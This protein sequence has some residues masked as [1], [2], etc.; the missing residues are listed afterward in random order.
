MNE[1]AY[2]APA[3]R[4]L[5]TVEELTQDGILVKLGSRS[6][7]FTLLSD[8]VTLTGSIVFIGNDVRG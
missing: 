8:N 1:L 3:L 7:G 2:E 4:V 5:G 6:D